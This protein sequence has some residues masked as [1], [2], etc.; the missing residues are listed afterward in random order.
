MNSQTETFLKAFLYYCFLNDILWQIYNYFFYCD[1]NIIFFL[2]GPMTLK[3]VFIATSKC[4]QSVCLN[5]Y[6]FRVNN[7]RE[8][9]I[10]KK[11]VF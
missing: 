2:A 3:L 7:K 8:P 6:N 1:N 9:Y 4:I 10:I 5:T 11:N